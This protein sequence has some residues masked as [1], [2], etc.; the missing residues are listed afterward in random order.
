MSRYHLKRLAAPSTWK[1]K[2]KELTYVTRPN[3]GPH[4]FRLGMPLNLIMREILGYGE[5]A[6]DVKNI[7][8][9]KA[10]LIDGIRR[11]DP[12]FIVGL[13][14]SLTVEDKNE[15]FRI[16]LDDKSKISAIKI[17]KEE[18]NV[19]PC[20][21]TGKKIL[22]GKFQINLY[23]GK[24]ILVDSGN[25]G[26][27]KVGDSLMIGLPKQEIKAHLALEKKKTIYLVGGKNLG[28]TG[29]V[30]NI[31]GDN[32]FYRA[33]SGD[34]VETLKKYAFVVGEEKSAVKLH[35]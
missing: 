29:V 19:K 24:N 32:I 21:I 4:S 9:N 1:I 6:R 26:T 23:D 20:K 28:E 31:K 8:N 35:E 3:P 33:K 12:K 16:I 22:S 13:F 15:S 34:I 30:E 25:Y 7:L 2:R 18:A 14:D 17:N 10:I 11:K 5:T 27:Y